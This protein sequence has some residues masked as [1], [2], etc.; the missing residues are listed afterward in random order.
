MIFPNA[1]RNPRPWPLEYDD[2]VAYCI[3]GNLALYLDDNDSAWIATTDP[4][5]LRNWA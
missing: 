4:C 2:H 5:N 3:G 1:G